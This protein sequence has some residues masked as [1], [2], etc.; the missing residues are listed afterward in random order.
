LSGKVK[1]KGN[2]IHV[3]KLVAGVYTHVY[4]LNLKQLKSI[5]NYYTNKDIV[6]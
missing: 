1:L 5:L 2:V 4:L 6:L 3:Y